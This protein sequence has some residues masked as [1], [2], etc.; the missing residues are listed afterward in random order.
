MTSPALRYHQ[1][2]HLDIFI[3]Y[4]HAYICYSF[5]WSEHIQGTFKFLAIP[6]KDCN[7]QFLSFSVTVGLTEGGPFSQTKRQHTVFSL[8]ECRKM[9]IRFILRIAEPLEIICKNSHGFAFACIINEL[10]ERSHAAHLICLRD[11][12]TL[13]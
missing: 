8:R 12:A 1:Y 5:P 9:G 10:A 3:E 6:V 11:H 7:C 13:I 2:Q 4:S